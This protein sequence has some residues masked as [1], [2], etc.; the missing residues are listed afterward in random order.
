MRLEKISKNT[1]Y[2]ELL[3][4]L[5]S[6]TWTQKKRGA[7]VPYFENVCRTDFATSYRPVTMVRPG[8]DIMVCYSGVDKKS[9]LL[10]KVWK[11]R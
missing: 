4:F 1:P 10:A 3:K 6:S 2:T 5:Y 9:D 8:R 7:N 11:Q